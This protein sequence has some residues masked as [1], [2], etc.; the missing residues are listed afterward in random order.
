MVGVRNKQG[1]MDEHKTATDFVVRDGHLYV[2]KT[3]DDVMVDVAVYAP[4]AWQSAVIAGEDD[5]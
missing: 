3:V 2:T 1:H 5:D 4:E